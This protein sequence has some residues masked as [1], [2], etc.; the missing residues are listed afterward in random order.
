MHVI[1]VDTN[2]LISALLGRSYP[3]LITREL[4]LKKMVTNVI[5]NSVFEEY[6]QVFSYNKF[7][8]HEKFKSTS[9]ELINDIAIVSVKI[10][11]GTHFN[12][13]SDADDNK[14]LDL[15]YTANADFLITGNK[16]HF[17]FAKFKNTEIIS[18][19][20]YWNTYWK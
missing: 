12:I 5:S 10:N 11:P 1:A 4:I 20:E 7:A 3:F 17:P 18:P 6:G 15:V 13:L 19:Q 2:V 16:K 14:F 8:K 9:V